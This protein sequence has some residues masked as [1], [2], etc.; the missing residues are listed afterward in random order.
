MPELK[1]CPFCG[2]KN[3]HEMAH[4]SCFGWH[5]AHEVWCWDCHA[6]I[7][8]LAPTDSKEQ[9]KQMAFEAWNRRANDED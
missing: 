6:T 3:I 2:G 9:A 4:Y 8:V 7:E 1:P 5:R